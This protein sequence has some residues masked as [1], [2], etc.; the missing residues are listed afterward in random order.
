MF[1]IVQEAVHNAL[2]HSAAQNI[3][4]AI[5]SNDK[6]VIQVSDDGKG[7][8]AKHSVSGNGLGNMKSRAAAMDMEMAVVANPG[9]GTTVILQSNTTN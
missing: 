3:S 6:L 7:L 9:E 4:I 2:K 1:R 8:G 5:I